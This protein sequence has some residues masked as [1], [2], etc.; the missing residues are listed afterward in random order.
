MSL[1]DLASMVLAPTAVKD[2]K[3]YNAIPNDQD[4]TFSRGTEATRVNSA[5]LIEKARTN[6]LLQSNTFDTTWENQ[7]G[8]GGSITSGQSGYDGT[9]NAWLIEKDNT[10]FRRIQQYVSTSGVFTYSVYAKEGTA[11]IMALRVVSSSSERVEFDLSDGTIS[12]NQ[13]EIDAKIEAVG[14]DG[15]YRCSVTR[16][17]AIT[18]VQIYV[19][20][21][22]TIGDKNI[23]IQ[24]SQ[25]ES[26]LVATD[27]I[28]TTTSSVTVGVTDN[29]PR[30]DYSGGGCP[31][32]LLEPQRTNLFPQSEY[33]KDSTH[34]TVQNVSFSVNQGISP[35]GQNN[36]IKVV[37]NS[38]GAAYWLND[39]TLTSGQPYVLSFYAKSNG[40]D[41]LQVTNS[42]GVGGSEKEN[43]DIINGTSDGDYATGDA[44]IEEFGNGWYK[45]IVKGTANASTGRMVIALSS[46]LTMTRLGGVTPSGDDGVLLYGF[47]WEQGSYSTS[48]I[49][50]YSVSSTR[51]ADSCSLTN[52]SNL[53]G[54][55]EGTMFA[56]FEIDS[57]NTNDFNRVLAI[58]DGTTNNRIFIFAQNTEVFRFYVANGGAAQ[59]DIVSTTSILGGRHKVAFAY[60][61]NDFIAYVDG[62]QVGTDTSGTIPS[63]SNVYVGTNEAGSTQPLKGGINQTILFP[64]RLTNDQLAELTK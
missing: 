28:D 24:D 20:W 53:I 14:S 36:A 31:S 10:S 40:W 2:G 12:F 11:S 19:E 42:T 23:Y 9:N 60:K 41:Y 25:L 58:G 7:L 6:Y 55:R 57:D 35:E 38:T 45:I 56:D 30:V 17:E 16:N 13:N 37:P 51:V 18:Q 26:G 59:V 8:V 34:W 47:Q 1:I 3:V 33:L 5:G 52:A 44:V 21:N 50:T 43:F 29:L 4:F 63:C 15:W 49:P 39:T 54:Q 27:Y 62:V 61:A 46:G 64:T 22:Q 32:L 48:Y